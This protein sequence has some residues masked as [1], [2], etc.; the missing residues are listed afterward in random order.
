MY[1]VTNF[2]DVIIINSLKIPF[3]RS[4]TVQSPFRGRGRGRGRRG[5]R[6]R[7]LR[8]EGGE[9]SISNHCICS[10]GRMEGIP[11]HEFSTVFAQP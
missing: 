8:K 6:R 3:I 2:V 4:N 9:D 7:R 11:E 5:R 10:I 1:V